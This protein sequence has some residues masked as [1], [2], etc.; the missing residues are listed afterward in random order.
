MNLLLPIQSVLVLFII[1]AAS[2]AVLQFRGGT[3]RFGAMLFWIMV[4]AVAILAII[5]PEQTT[6][7]AKVVGIGRGVDVVLYVSI[8]ILFYLVFR[9]HVYVEDLRSEISRLIREV[10]LKDV[11]KGIKT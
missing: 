10:S 9:L 3:I 11:K 8:A 6:Q 7:F 2:R 4:W 5:Y 1:F